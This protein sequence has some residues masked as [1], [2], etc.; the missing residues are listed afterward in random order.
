MSLAGS[1]ASGS[2]NMKFALIWGLTFGTLDGA[3]IEILKNVGKD[4]IFIFGNT[5]EQVEELRRNGYQPFNYYQKD[6]DLRNV[7]DQIVAGRF[8]AQDP[9]PY[10]NIMNKLQS[11]DYF[12]SFA[13]FRSY[14]DAHAVVDAKYKDQ[15]AWIDSVLQNIVNMSF[16][17]SDRTI[18]EYAEK[19]W[20]IK[21]LKVD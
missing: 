11:Y 3:N 12:Q 9:T 5:V 13:D 6:E 2:S 15:K 16:F 4:N 18:A 7:V 17:S 19:I 8:F 10:K 14:M 20:K 21:P 1:E